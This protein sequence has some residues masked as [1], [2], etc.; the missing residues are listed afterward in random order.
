MVM[1][2]L[3]SLKH[4]S[5]FSKVLA[6]VNYYKW[7]LVRWHLVYHLGVLAHPSPWILLACFMQMWKLAGSGK[8]ERPIKMVYAP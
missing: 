8:E 5:T 2:L 7:C 4:W 1:L 6:E 3:V